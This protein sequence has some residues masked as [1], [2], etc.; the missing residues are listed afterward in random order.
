MFLVAALWGGLMTTS[1]SALSSGRTGPG[2]PVPNPSAGR[3]VWQ[4]THHYFFKKN[5]RCE[6]PEITSKIHRFSRVGCN[7]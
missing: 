2:L 7:A 3:K 5:H 1:S 4:G 6:Q